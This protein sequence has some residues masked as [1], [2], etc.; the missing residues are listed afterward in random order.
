MIV[1]DIYLTYL[2]SLVCGIFIIDTIR[3]IFTIMSRIERK[4]RK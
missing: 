4:K 1:A 3:L 2:L